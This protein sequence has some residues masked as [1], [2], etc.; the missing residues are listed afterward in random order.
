MASSSSKA[1]I[2]AAL[3]ANLG[4]AASKFVAA[5]FTGSSAMLSEGIH[6]VVDAGNSVLLL[7]GLSRGQK[8]ADLA[9]PFGYGKEYYF[10][11]LI[12]AI[13]LFAIGGGMSVYEGI[14][15]FEHPQPQT[16]IGWNYA[17]LAVALGFEA[18]S[19]YVILQ[20]VGQTR[21]SLT[22]WQAVQ[23]SK[24]PGVFA[25]LYENAAAVLGLII[26]SLGTALGYYLQEPRIDGAASV[27]IGFVLIGVA[28]A[29]VR[30]TKG[31]LI[32]EAA[33]PALQQAVR[34]LVLADPAIDDLAPPLTMHFGPAD[35]LLVL[36]VRF[37]PDLTT[38]EVEATTN[39][40]E[41]AI[42]AAHPDVK[43]IYVEAHAPAPPA[44]PATP[45][46][47]DYPA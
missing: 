16:N 17:T 42:R 43:R 1:G 3:A 9:H 10:W 5:F 32:G 37:R 11:S 26:A 35:I 13:L 36:N 28:V 8:A 30:E 39:R 2:Y 33:D 18:F 44:T 45:A 31:L 4:I 19:T 15:H 34:T 47:P 7:L 24:D 21:G 41:A 20:Q 27:L 40:L 23:S 25:V 46:T 6:S 12:V 22:Y 29:L 38:P 14:T